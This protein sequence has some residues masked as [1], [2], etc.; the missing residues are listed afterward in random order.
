MN[1]I[2]IVIITNNFYYYC[3]YFLVWLP[4]LCCV[5]IIFIKNFSLCI[6]GFKGASPYPSLPAFVLTERIC[7]LG[8]EEEIKV[9]DE[10]WCLCVVKKKR[11]NFFAYKYS[12]VKNVS[13]N[14]STDCRRLARMS[15]FW[16]PN[17]FDQVSCFHDHG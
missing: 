8:Y 15:N 7:I 5:V 12:S 13:Q 6:R 16:E 3:L 10:A 14:N 2:I 9:V 17:E 1:L 11:T 4:S